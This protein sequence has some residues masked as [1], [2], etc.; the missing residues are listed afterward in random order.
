MGARTVT[1]QPRAAREAI[2]ASSA[3]IG[4][5]GHTP[6]S[7]VLSPDIAT[8]AAARTGVTRLS[9]SHLKQVQTGSE[10]KLSFGSP[11]R[12]GVIRLSALHL[13]AGPGSL[14]QDTKLSFASRS[15]ERSTLKAEESL[16]GDVRRSLDLRNGA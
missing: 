10:S 9:A 7:A 11:A 16:A 15:V 5:R 12:A 3:R 2:L 6:A 1:S 13:Q 4:L 14:D 8:A